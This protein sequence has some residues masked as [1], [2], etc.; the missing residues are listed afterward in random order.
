MT[1]KTKRSMDL[2]SKRQNGSLKK[3][4]TLCSSVLIRPTVIGSL[5]FP[6]GPVFQI[7]LRV[8]N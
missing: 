6:T 8:V 7:V 5:L 3:G 1:L 4:G 2:H